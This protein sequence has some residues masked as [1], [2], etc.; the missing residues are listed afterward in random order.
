[1]GERLFGGALSIPIHDELFGLVKKN[2][3]RQ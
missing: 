1:M 2:A 3:V